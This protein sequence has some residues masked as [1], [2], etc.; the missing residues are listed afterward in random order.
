MAD[1]PLELEP[2][3]IKEPGYKTG[4]L[5]F[6]EGGNMVVLL[7]GWETRDH[8]L[9]HHAS[10]AYRQFVQRTQHLLAGNFVVK[11]FRTA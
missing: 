6:E 7:T 8:C 5:L 1:L 9:Q 2:V 10:R 3:L 11:L 4:G